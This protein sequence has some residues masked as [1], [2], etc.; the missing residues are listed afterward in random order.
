VDPAVDAQA[1]PAQ[2]RRLEAGLADDVEVQ[3]YCDEADW[4]ALDY[5]VVNR[6]EGIAAWPR[7]QKQIDRLKRLAPGKPIIVFIDVLDQNLKCRT[8]CTRRRTSPRASSR[9]R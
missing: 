8:G 5:Y 1:D 3:A 2:L 6:G 7:V 9:P 4:I